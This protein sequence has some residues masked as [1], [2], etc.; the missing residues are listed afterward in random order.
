MEI[1]KA[2]QLSHLCHNIRFFPS[3]VHTSM[4]CGYLCCA[5]IRRTPWLTCVRGRVYIVRG[6][7][8]D[9]ELFC[10]AGWFIVECLSAVLGEVQSTREEGAGQQICDKTMS[11]ITFIYFHIYNLF[12][13]QMPTYI[14]KSGKCDTSNDDHL[15]EPRIIVYPKVLLLFISSYHP[16]NKL[17]RFVLSINTSQRQ[18][19]ESK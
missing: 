16:S 13:H 10:R 15:M 19:R 2:C 5:Y 8:L 12:A 17:Q 3:H 4:T 11:G 7:W 14:Y 6:A 1:T 18:P 9:M